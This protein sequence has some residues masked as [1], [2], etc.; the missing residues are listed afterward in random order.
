MTLVRSTL[1]WP[2]IAG[3]GISL[4]IAG[5]FT[6]WNYGLGAGWANLVVAT[7]LMAILC[8]G[9]ALCVAELSASRPH[10]GGLYSYCQDA[11][12]RWVGY[13]VGVGIFAALAIGTG[14]ATT[15]ISAYCTHVLGFGGP[16]LK[17]GLCVAIAGIHLR[18]VGEAM[19]WLVGAGILSLSCI[20]L[21]LVGMAPHFS[22]EH[23]ATP[24]LP[25]TIT[26]MGVFSCVPFAI[27]L[28]ISI[29]Q[30]AAASE[31]VENPGYSMPRGMLVAIATLL[32][33][34][35]GILLLAVG[36]GG[37]D[38]VAAADDPLFAALSSPL[39]GGASPVL[40]K[41]VGLGGMLGL[42]ATMFSLIYSASRQLYAIARDGYLP[43]VIS[44]TNARGAP[45][46]TIVLVACIA[47]LTSFV[48]AERILLCVVLL[49]TASYVVLLAAFIRLRQR[50]PHRPRPFRAWGGRGTAAVCMVL[51]LLVLVASFQSDAVAL[52]GLGLFF[53]AAILIR[54]LNRDVRSELPRT[55]GKLADV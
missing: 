28:F 22:L 48:R 53:M 10:A 44:R 52:A 14:A 31:E 11:F 32:V 29:E 21:F 46:V 37:V 54:V 35:L 4:V 3:L 41:V 8:F 20:A 51:A 33:S 18:G 24:T 40:A 30:T 13:L 9:L 49:L 16:W 12:G 50:E 25:L 6:G 17:V 27:W 36:G 2:Q 26:P 47:I 19:R 5:Q 1:R 45:D 55:D 38:H 34:A 39:V 7:V 42:I 43:A 15:F 23:L